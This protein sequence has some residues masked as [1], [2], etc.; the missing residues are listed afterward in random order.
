MNI[1]T[2]EEA[3]RQSK[4]NK[5]RL[6]SEYIEIEVKQAI[7]EGRTMVKIMGNGE[8]IPLEI[9][10]ELKDKGYILILKSRGIFIRWS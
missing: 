1:P 4:R 6:L 9:T 2:K 7:K 8:N 5:L 3:L 10:E